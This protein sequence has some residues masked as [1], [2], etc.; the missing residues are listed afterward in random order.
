MRPLYRIDGFGSAETKEHLFAFPNVPY[1][2]WL[3]VSPKGAGTA[4]RI[5]REGPKHFFRLP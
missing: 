5:L 3:L 2:A 4:M 1:V